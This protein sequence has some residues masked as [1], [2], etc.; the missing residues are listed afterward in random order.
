MLT[1]D[2]RS[3][4]KFRFDISF[5]RSIIFDIVLDTPNFYGMPRTRLQNS[6]T[7]PESVEL[8]TCNKSRSHVR[9]ATAVLQLNIT[10]PLPLPPT[11]TQI[12]RRMPHTK[13]RDRWQHRQA[14]KHIKDPL[15]RKRIPLNP[16]CELNKPINR[17]KLSQNQHTRYH[18]THA[19]TELTI[20]KQ[21]ETYT[22]LRTF[23]QPSLASALTFPAFDKT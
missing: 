1:Y 16:Q 10:N 13:H 4:W 22:A 19:K 20:I 17:P 18:P 11:T 2:E 7:P 9:S 6:S 15:V 12:L 8:S 3:A 21:H 5:S 14:L 23:F